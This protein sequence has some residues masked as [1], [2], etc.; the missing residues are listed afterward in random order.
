MLNSFPVSTGWNNTE[1][2]S[3]ANQQMSTLDEGERKELVDR[4]QVLIA[5]N[6]PTIPL[7]YRNVYSACN[8]DKFDGFFY[9]PGGVG[10]GVPTEYNKLVFIYGEWKGQSTASEKNN[11]ASTNSPSMNAP[12]I[13]TAVMAF[14]VVLMLYRQKKVMNRCCDCRTEFSGD[15][16]YQEGWSMPSHFFDSYCQFFSASLYARGSTVKRAREPECRLTG[17]HR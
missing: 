11:T 1:F 9:T 2:A 14:A 3:L 5:E 7:L 10:G 12:G 13:L 15:M 8:Q 16:F 6:V 4:M 17:G